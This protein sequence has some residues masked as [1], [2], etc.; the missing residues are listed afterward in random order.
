MFGQA[1]ETFA[2]RIRAS[3][4]YYYYIAGAL[5]PVLLLRLMIISFSEGKKYIK[6]NSEECIGEWGKFP[7]V[8]ER[9]V[10]VIGSSCS[11]SGE[12]SGKMLPIPVFPD[13]FSCSCFPLFRS[14]L[15]LLVLQNV[16]L[17][18]LGQ[19][20]MPVESTGLLSCNSPSSTS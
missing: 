7:F 13:C 9:T 19:D 1:L 12:E 3:A 17:G 20:P 18:E 11:S 8:K 6:F 2:G 14:P 4:N 10:E 15:S 5:T 16:N